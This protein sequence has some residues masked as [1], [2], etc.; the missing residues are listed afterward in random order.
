MTEAIHIERIPA[1]ARIARRLVIIEVAFSLLRIAIL[2]SAAI[3]AF[4]VPLLLS[5][6]AV[7]SITALK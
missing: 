1:T 6:L 7:A 3:T 2:I 4:R 5:I